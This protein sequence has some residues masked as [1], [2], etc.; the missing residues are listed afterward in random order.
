MMGSRLADPTVK[1][2]KAALTRWAGRPD[3]QIVR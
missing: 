3:N 2:K 1:C